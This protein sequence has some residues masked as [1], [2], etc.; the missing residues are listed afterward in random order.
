MQSVGLLL[1]AYAGPVL[2]GLVFLF[3]G[4]M[5]LVEPQPFVA[6]LQR[7]DLVAQP[8]FKSLLFVAVTQELALG[9]ALLTGCA[10]VVV[11]PLSMLTIAVLTVVT[12]RAYRANRITDCGCY[13]GMIDLTPPQSALIN[14]GYIVSLA[15]ALP[16]RTG[17]GHWASA[18]VVAVV[19]IA[20]VLVY[21]ES[22]KRMVQMRPPL[23]ELGRVQAGRRFDPKWL[24]GAPVDLETG[25]RLVAFL[26]VGCP[27]CKPWL[28]VLR[29]LAKSNQGMPVVG[30]V[31]GDTSAVVEF[32]AE[33]QVEL[34]LVVISSARFGRLVRGTPVG[35][36]LVDGRIEGRYVGFLPRELALRARNKPEEVASVES[37]EKSEAHG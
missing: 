36:Y 29:A 24:P 6:H 26:G 14:V 21:R 10:P 4:F 12:L 13:H 18:V 2:V 15:V 23:V 35:A 1:L 37:T 32:M 5:K 20:T 34:P 19:A 17:F 31:A 11:L 22:L 9:A 8:R 7:L 27:M 28:P 33:Y 25:E 30:V 3:T 16:F